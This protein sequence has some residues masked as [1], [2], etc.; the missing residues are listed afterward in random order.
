M[1]TIFP[2]PNKKTS[3]QTNSHSS[4]QNSSPREVLAEDPQLTLKSKFQVR[5]G[6]L[7]SGQ[8]VVTDDHI[9]PTIWMILGSLMI[10]WLS[11]PYINSTI[12]TR[13]YLS[14]EE[15]FTQICSD[16]G[17]LE[18]VQILD[19]EPQFKQAEVDCIFKDPSENLRLQLFKRSSGWEVNVSDKLNE[20]RAW[21][22][23]IFV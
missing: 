18:Y 4:G 6:D 9:W 10:L 15:E 13:R 21:Y 12:L 11:F 7:K 20:E 17:N 2:W 19:Y 3:S 8:Y 1:S 5:P 16:R 22:W 23:P 14:Q